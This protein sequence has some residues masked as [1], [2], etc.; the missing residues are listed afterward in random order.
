MK[1]KTFYAVIPARG[2]SKGVPKKNIILV[3]KKPLI[4]YT[5]AQALESKLISK[6]IVSTDNK[7]IASISKNYGAIVPF[8]RPKK[9]SGDYSTDFE[10]FYHLAK[11]MKKKGDLPDYFVHMRPTNPIRKI[12]TIN[13]AI[14][15]ILNNGN[16][17]SLRSVSSA[18]QSPYKMWQIKNNELIQLIKHKNSKESHS[19]PRQL[20]PIVY[21]QNGY[22]DIIKSSVILNKKSITGNKILP[23]LIKEKIF[24]IDYPEDIVNVE[25]AI[26]KP[27]QKNIKVIIKH[28]V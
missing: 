23:Y 5:I 10:V 19:I 15:Y 18:N 22:I 24:E 13:K 2:G 20:L 28:P 17:D 4:S 7:E 3:N 16:Y 12:A 14:N 25:R 1:N 9:I 21:W 8:K 27:K 26:K 11:Y 6:V